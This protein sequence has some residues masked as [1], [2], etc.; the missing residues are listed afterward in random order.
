MAERRIRRLAE[1]IEQNFDCLSCA[2][3]CRV[4]TVRLS[5]RD[6]VKLSKHMRLSPAAFTRDYTETTPDEGLI[7]RRT[8]QGCVF[9]DG[10][11][12]LVYDA[13]PGICQDFPHTVRGDGS[14]LSRMWD[15]A[16]RACYCPIVF[17]TLEAIKEE[18]GFRG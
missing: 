2:N 11:H 1:E 15:F 4:A 17:N 16:D 3:C 12:C 13:R 8:E 5:D 9:L 6:L 10:N 14:F 7:L 18:V